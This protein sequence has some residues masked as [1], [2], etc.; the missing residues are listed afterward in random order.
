MHYLKKE[1]CLFLKASQPKTALNDEM[2]YFIDFLYFFLRG[3]HFLI[4][5]QELFRTICCFSIVADLR[6]AQ[7]DQISE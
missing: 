4:E 2:L 7:M 1:C 3:K 5:R 6:K